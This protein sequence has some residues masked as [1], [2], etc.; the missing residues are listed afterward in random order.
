[1]HDPADADVHA[2]IGTKEGLAL[3]SAIHGTSSTLTYYSLMKAK[4]TP[5]LR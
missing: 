4:G 3:T 1:M 5:H 2:D